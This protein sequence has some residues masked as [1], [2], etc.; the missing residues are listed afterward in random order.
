MSQVLLSG[1]AD[2]IGPDPAKQIAVLQANNV[3][4]L[5]LRGVGG[6]NVLDLNK[7]EIDTFRQQLRDA[8]I[9]IACI[10]SPIGKVQIRSDLEAHFSRFKIAVERAQQFNTQNIRIFSFYHQDEQAHA[11]RQ[12]VIAQLQ[13]MV[14]YAANAGVT[15]LHENESGIYGDTPER[16]LDLL[17]SINQPHFRAIFDPANFLQSDCNPKDQCWPLLAKFVDY[18]HIKDV[19]T[20]SGQVVPAGYGDGQIEWTLAQALNNGFSGYLALE[21]HLNADH[22]VHGGNGAERFTKAVAG[23]RRV[24]DNLGITTG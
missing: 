13:R 4:Y 24:L 18:F 12:E 19:D 15:V 16:C 5:D 8:G 7:A 17:K 6:K 21:P 20:P 10:G 23:L 11:C 1:F 22:P 2:E 14:E 3:H 9:G